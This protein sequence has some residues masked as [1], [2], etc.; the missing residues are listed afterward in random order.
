MVEKL[1]YR[2]QYKMVTNQQYKPDEYGKDILLK[3]DK[4]QVMMQWEQNLMEKCIDELNP[5]NGD[6][7]EVG[8]GMVKMV[9]FKLKRIMIND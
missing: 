7:L 8:F 2:G 1:T 3:D 5:I 6:V 4:H 9:E